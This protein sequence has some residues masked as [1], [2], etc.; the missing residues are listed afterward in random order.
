MDEHQ[1]PWKLLDLWPGEP[2]SKL[3]FGM[4]AKAVTVSSTW[5]V[6]FSQ[7]KGGKGPQGPA[8][9]PYALAFYGRG[10]LLL[11]AAFRVISVISFNFNCPAQWRPIQRTQY[12]KRWS[13]MQKDRNWRKTVSLRESRFFINNCKEL[14]KVPGRILALAL[15]AH[16]CGNY[17]FRNG[18]NFSIVFWWETF[19][20]F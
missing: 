19:W 1:K 14:L 15:A 8:A 5:T 20:M 18:M 2:D 4:L 9:D 11:P 3:P 6:A 12:T 7:P 17:F 16:F 10:S 13:R